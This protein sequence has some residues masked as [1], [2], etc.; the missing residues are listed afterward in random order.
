M[1]GLEPY[2]IQNW[3]KRGFLTSPV[4]R[5]YS[6]EQFARIIIINML[7]ESLQIETVCELLSAIDSPVSGGKGGSA[8]LYHRYADMLLDP[9]L[10]MRDET[11]VRGAAERAV[12]DMDTGV[13]GRARQLSVIL[14]TVYYA[15]TASRLRAMAA[16]M[17]SHLR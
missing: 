4:K 2:M 9:A 8:E 11:A 5:L 15:H 17:L 16:E 14:T 10:D 13:S 7:R 3:V 6:E 12:A 1:T